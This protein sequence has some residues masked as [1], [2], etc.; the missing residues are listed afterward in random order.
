MVVPK[1][2][3][4]N[5]PGICSRPSDL[6]DHRLEVLRD[7]PL[8][9]H[10]AHIVRDSAIVPIL[11]SPLD[12]ASNRVFRMARDVSPDLSPLGRDF[13]HRVTEFALV[14]HFRRSL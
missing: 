13:M 11:A 3:E 10:W 4:D 12:D 8:A 6:V 9:S 14:A 2:L 5:G 7:L 1:V